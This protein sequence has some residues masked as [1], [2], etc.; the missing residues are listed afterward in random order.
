MSNLSVNICHLSYQGLL[1]LQHSRIYEILRVGEGIVTTMADAVKVS[2]QNED[3]QNVIGKEKVW[4]S[5]LEILGD[6]Y[7]CMLEYVV[8][9][10]QMPHMLFTSLDDYRARGSAASPYFTVTHYTDLMDSKGVVLVRGDIVFT[11]RLSD[12]EVLFLPRFLVGLLI[13]DPRKYLVLEIQGTEYCV[14]SY[15]VANL[16]SCRQK[17]CWR[18]HIH[19]T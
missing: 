15:N 12:E 5:V 19:F 4:W 17:L 10:A 6:P 8:F 16:W 9:A 14:M 7:H 2:I 3:E 11:S 1:Y 18:Q 13:H